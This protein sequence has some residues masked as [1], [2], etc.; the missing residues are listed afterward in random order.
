MHM[1]TSTLGIR[2][3][4]VAVASALGLATTV[5][6]QTASNEPARDSPQQMVDA[7]HSAFGVHHARAVHA[8][9]ILLT[10]TFMPSV[11]ARQLANS[12][13]FTN[14]TLQIT[15]RFSDFTGIPDIPDT[16]GGANPRGFAIKF[17][18]PGDASMD[19]VAH[20]FN[21]FPTATT[22]EFGYLLRAIGN[23]GPEAAKP[24]D[25]DQFLAAHP[26]AR[27][28]LTTQKPA[29]ISYATLAYF[30]VNSFKFTNASGKSRFT[31]YRF[32]PLAGEQFL[33]AA[34]LKGKGPNYLS[35][36]I[37]TRI[38]SGPIVYDWYAQIATDGDAIA[39]PSVA[40][41]ESRQLVKLGTITISG[42]VADQPATDKVTMFIPNNVPAGIEPA[43]PM[44]TIRSA[45]YPISFAGRQ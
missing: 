36:E 14:G 37:A 27:T 33:D 22:D 12:A 2:V 41:P 3:I 32:I 42:L 17:K 44:L 30:G 19:I 6:A 38:A 29:P 39:D 4:N 9:G 1:K 28:F 35:E 7:L 40:W 26:I 16:A 45:A 24:T 31:R 23:S 20:S 43:D 11:E 25:L 10:G 8:K 18:L 34:A 5:H 15:A 21:G 13:V